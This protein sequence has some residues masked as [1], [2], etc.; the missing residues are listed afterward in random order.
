MGCLA[1][2]EYERTFQEHGPLQC[3]YQL[4]E[5]IVRDKLQVSVERITLTCR[6]AAFWLRARLCVVRFNTLCLSSF[7]FHVFRSQQL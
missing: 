7:Q 3:K 2:Y 1:H 5:Y 4:V 6:A